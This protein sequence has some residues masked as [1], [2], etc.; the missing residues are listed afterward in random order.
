MNQVFARMTRQDSECTLWKLW[1]RQRVGTGKKKKTT[2]NGMER[3]GEE[4]TEF[5]VLLTNY[6]DIWHDG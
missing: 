5:T 4:R 6:L 3:N 1:R 2:V